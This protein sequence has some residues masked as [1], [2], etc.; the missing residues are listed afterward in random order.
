MTTIVYAGGILC[1]DSLVTQNMGRCG[2]CQK[3]GRTEDGHL[4]AA[5]G[6]LDALENFAKWAENREGDPTS[7]PDE[8]GENQSCRILITPEGKV[9]EWERFGW[10]QVTMDFFAWGTGADYAIGALAMGATPQQAVQVGIDFDIYSGGE[11]H[12]LYLVAP[13]EEGIEPAE[14]DVLTPEEREALE[15]ERDALKTTTVLFRERLGLE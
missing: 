14:D 12:T 4:Y 11:I 15:A 3:I 1:A 5:S 8:K 13:A 9:R 7:D 2:F 10:T 6:R